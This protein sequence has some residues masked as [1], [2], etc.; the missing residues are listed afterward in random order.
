MAVGFDFARA[1]KTAGAS[2]TALFL[3]VAGLPQT[4]LKTVDPEAP[5]QIETALQKSGRDLSGRG[6]PPGGGGQRAL[7][8]YGFDL[9]GYI[10]IS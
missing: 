9:D 3:G 1:S 10:V 7:H 8:H 4:A 6:K 2:R 5:S